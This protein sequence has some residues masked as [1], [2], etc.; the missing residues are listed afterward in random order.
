MMT[1]FKIK[2]NLYML[3]SEDLKVFCFGQTERPLEERHKDGDWAKFHNYLKARGEKLIVIGWWEGVPVLDTWVHDWLKIQPTIRKFAEWFSHKVDLYILA[4][5]IEKKFFPETPKTKEDLTLKKHQQQFV[6]KVLSSWE[7]WK[8]FLLFAKCR[9]G[10]SIMVLSAIA[11]KGV[12]VSLIVSRYTSPIQSWREDSEN[13]SEYNNLVFIDLSQKDYLEQIEYWYNTDKQLVLWTTVQGNNRWKKIPCDVDL[14]VYD[15]A[16][17]GYGS[18]QFKE[19]RKKFDCKVL[20]VTGTAFD[21]IWDFSE[22][23][24]YTYSYFEEQLDKKQGLNNAPSMRVVLAKYDTDSYQKLYG[25]DP[26]AMKNLFSMNE[27]K[28]DFLEPSLVQDFYATYF[29]DQKFLK[30]KD[31][32]LNGKFHIYMA[33]P[34]V[35]ACHAS[36]KYLEKTKFSPLVVTGDA[37]KDPDSIRK[38]VAE[39]E[40]SIILT[41]SANVLGVTV[42]EID[43]V[44]NATEGESL[45]FWTQ[46]AFRGGSSDRDWDVIDFCPQRSLNSLRETF[47]AA[48]DNA[49]QISEFNMLDFVS[50]TEWSDGFES[51][52]Q[53]QVASI[54]ASDVSN[55]I[56][57]VSGTVRGMD[58]EKLAHCQFNLNI[59]STEK[60]KDN[61]RVVNENGANGKSNLKREGEASEKKDNS[62]LLAKKETIRSILERVP[63]TIYHCIKSD[64]VPNSIADVLN[65]EHYIHNTLDSEGIIAELVHEGVID[66][67][68]FSYRINQAVVDIQHAMKEDECKTLE[69]LACTW[70][71]HQS[72]PVELVDELLDGFF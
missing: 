17:H 24:S 59:F 68:C 48:C 2:K 11:R 16:H 27:D 46:F 66:A 72:M 12:K 18:K 30:P 3:A 35:A 44:I 32:L 55:T 43:T 50:I 38:H 28:T 29:G 63:L 1:G 20:F 62:E 13:F 40:Y 25:D 65:S 57:M 6:D 19:L 22:S 15:E 69:K 5:R 36:A 56:S 52:S 42:R 39:N 41:V 53:D 9:A 70:K 21:M 45:N 10:K 4:N 31:R 60:Q 58:Y 37:K 26:D 23:N 54:L 47:I 64:S 33:L 7:E 49:P 51:I 71:D 67:K 61:K 14:I 8:E 34:S